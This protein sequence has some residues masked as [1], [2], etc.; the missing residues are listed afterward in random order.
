MTQ[1]FDYLSRPIR[2]YI[3]EQGWHALSAIQEAAIRACF[4]RTEDLILTAPTAAGKTEAAFLPAISQVRHW[5][6]VVKLLAI[7]PMIS[8]LN[9]QFQRIEQLGDSPDLGITD[10][11]G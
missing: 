4:E 2:Q 3:Y 1:A 11:H 7:S 5:V 8:L 10:W 6:G 9:D